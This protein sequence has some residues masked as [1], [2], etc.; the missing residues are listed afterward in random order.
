MHYEAMKYAF[1]K[2]VTL[3]STVF[4]YIKEPIQLLGAFK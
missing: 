3:L 2:Y 4:F 1:E